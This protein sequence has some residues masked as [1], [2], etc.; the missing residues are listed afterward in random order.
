[1]VVGGGWGGEGQL[2]C[3][4]LETWELPS[5]LLPRLQLQEDEQIMQIEQVDANLFNLFIRY[6][7]KKNF[8]FPEA[9]FVTLAQNVNSL[10]GE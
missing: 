1:M 7:F 8:T 4:S 10:H 9:E 6:K 5:F 2:P 3:Y